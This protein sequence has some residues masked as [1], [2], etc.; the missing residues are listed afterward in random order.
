LLEL[1]LRIEAAAIRRGVRLPAGLSL[2]GVFRPVIAAQAHE[3]RPLHG[4]SPQAHEP[5]PA[6][7][8]PASSA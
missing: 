1:P 8:L 6:H 5:R 7:D 2:L 3:S 4:V